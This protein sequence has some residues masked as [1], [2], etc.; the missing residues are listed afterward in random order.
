M[1][2]IYDRNKFLLD[3]IQEQVLPRSAPKHLHH[4]QKPFSNS[5]REYLL[6]ARTTLEY[7]AE[8]IKSKLLDSPLPPTSPV[9]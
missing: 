7:E 8:E 4:P 3:C 6:E 1:D 2:S 9:D 5:A